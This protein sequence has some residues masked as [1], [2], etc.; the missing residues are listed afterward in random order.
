MINESRGVATDKFEIFAVSLRKTGTRTCRGVAINEG[1]SCKLGQ[2]P[3]P[4]QSYFELRK[5]LIDLFVN[6]VKVFHPL[7]LLIIYPHHRYLVSHKRKSPTEWREPVLL[8]PE[9]FH[10][11]PLLPPS[12]PIFPTE[13]FSFLSELIAPGDIHFGPTIESNWS[14]PGN[15]CLFLFLRSFQTA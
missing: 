1:G 10:P 14:I 12:F 13:E 8:L 6:H 15:F 4:G 2:W 3:W 7:I 9:E 5:H 11:H